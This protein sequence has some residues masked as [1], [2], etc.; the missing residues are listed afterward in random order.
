MTRLIAIVLGLLFIGETYAQDVSPKI[1][2]GKNLNNLTAAV[3]CAHPEAAKIGAEIL[4]KGGNAVDASI[5]IQW[6]LAVCYPQAGNIG[7]GGFMVVR[8][9]DGGVNTLDFRETAPAAAN[10]DMYLDNTGNVEDGKCIDSHLA[11]GVPGSVR[12]LYESSERYGVLKMEDLIAPAIVLAERGFPI[13][14][15]Q[16]TLFNQYR[17]EFQSREP[18]NNPF[19]KTTAQW[20]EGD[21]LV[22][23]VLAATLKRISENGAEEFYSGQTAQLIVNEMK[24]GG[25]IINLNDLADYTAIWREPI[26]NKFRNYT[27]YSMP[28]PS[29]GG[30][31][32]AQ[33]LKMWE[34]ANPDDIAHNSVAYIHLVTEMERRVYADRSVYLG[35]PAFYNIPKKHLLKDAYLRK[36][37]KNFDSK[38]ATSSSKIKAGSFDISEST[39]T[40]HLSV[41]DQDGNAVSVTTTLNGHYGSKILV[42]G[43]GFFLNNEMDDFSVKPGTPNMFGLVGGA[44]NAIEP[45]KRML[46]SM[47]PTIVEKNNEL[48]LVAGSPGGSTIITSVFQ[49]IMNTVVFRS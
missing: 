6:A 15:K 4:K 22:Q 18:S 5:A 16:A 20:V 11:V 41:V 38:E 17:S 23:S 1:K 3:S 42:E 30:I 47:T 35:D 46:S 34:N 27:V 24:S 33:L 21:T 25:G 40:T 8:M 28:P 45:N 48:Y 44:V 13:T 10:K 37:M 7:G 32:I 49:T 14:A 9:K 26:R 19:V 43:G 2:L 29:S 12:G 36:R 31:A 39:E